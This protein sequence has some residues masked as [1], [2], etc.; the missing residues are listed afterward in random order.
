MDMSSHGNVQ[1]PT[2]IYLKNQNQYKENTCD[3]SAKLSYI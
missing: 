2:D 3:M 1:I